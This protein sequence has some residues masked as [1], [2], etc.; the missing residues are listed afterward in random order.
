MIEAVG[1]FG[2]MDDGISKPKKMLCSD[3]V[4]RV[5]KFNY[6]DSYTRALL[7]EYI[8]YRIALLLELP[9]LNQE[10]IYVPPELANAYSD[11]EG[12][13]AGIKVGSPLVEIDKN[14]ADNGL[15]R[16]PLPQ[17]YKSCVDNHSVRTESF[18]L[19]TSQSGNNSENSGSFSIVPSG[20]P[21]DT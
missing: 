20:N 15:F 12:M 19:G 10:L 11:V 14:I 17:L 2:N 3:N 6:P 8:S 1:F 7:H 4:M 13:S 16:E 9:V 21:Y 18:N 5:V